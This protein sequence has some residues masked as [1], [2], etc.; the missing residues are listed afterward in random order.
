MIIDARELLEYLDIMSTPI[1]DEW[2]DGWMDAV[3]TIREW[4]EEHQEEME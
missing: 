4:I 3:K 2:G 1:R